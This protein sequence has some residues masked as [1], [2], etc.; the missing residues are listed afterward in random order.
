[1]SYTIKIRHPL[2]R[3]ILDSLDWYKISM[4]EVVF[5]DFP[6]VQV[7]YRFINRGKTAFPE[8]F[9]MELLNQIEM[10]ADLALTNAEFQWM[11]TVTNYM[12]PT[13]LEWFRGF[14][15]DPKA[16][17]ICL[18]KG[19]LD[20]TIG[21][22]WY[23]RIFWETTLMA[24]IS[25]LYFLLATNPIPGG[26]MFGIE[27]A[28]DWEE[29]II[30]KADLLEGNGCHWIDF[31]TRRR[32]SYETQD[33]VVRNMRGRKGFLGTSNPHLAQKYGVPPHGTYAHE[34]I[35]AMMGI[36]GSRMA[37]HIWMKH[38]AEHFDGNLG[39]ALTDT[40]TTDVFLR[41][42]TCGVAKMF[43]GVRHDSKDPYAWGER[44]LAHYR[45]LGILTGNK[46][47]VFSDALTVWPPDQVMVDGAYNYI[48]LD[49][50]FRDR[51][52]PIGGI[53]TFFTND[54]CTLE[55]KAAG[56]KPLN[57]V[58]KLDTVDFG[59]G[60]VNVIKLSD[61][62]GKHCGDPQTVENTKREL[63]LR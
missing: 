24:L 23:S 36:Y 44:M 60:P 4:G 45:S 55:Q 21:G 52:Q 47:L 43:D 58:I 32:K 14:R 30:R 62:E 34:V 40:F 8:G 49:R 33:A 54:V 6:N 16:V 22:P 31:G 17:T 18:E 37:N 9:D 41:D 7:T 51:A 57:M 27:N 11:N 15:Y 3:S 59:R 56:I 48:P 46:R 10:L 63:G 28:A 12:R 20:I 2:I 25:E 35:C 42:F 50:H 53:G 29:R 1:M 13:Y 61:E 26:P 5:H 39:I 38:W 19:K